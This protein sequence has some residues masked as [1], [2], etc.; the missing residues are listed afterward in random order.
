MDY[1]GGSILDEKY[2]PVEVEAREEDGSKSRV[3]TIIIVIVV[4]LV[5]FLLYMIWSYMEGL[6]YNDVDPDDYLRLGGEHKD[7]AA[8]DLVGKY[9]GK[10]LSPVGHMRLGTTYYLNMKDKQ[11]AFDHFKMAIKGAEEK[12][13]DVEYIA[14]RIQ[15]IIRTG[16]QPIDEMDEELDIEIQRAL[17]EN[18]EER[19]RDLEQIREVFAGAAPANQEMAG[20]VGEI[21]EAKS[22]DE[23]Y[24]EKVILSKT[25]W[26]SDTQNVH[27]S[28]L[29]QELVQQYDIVAAENKK[30][31]NIQL[32]DY[33]GMCQWV[34]ARLGGRPLD[35]QRANKVLEVWDNNYPI[36]AMGGSVSEQ[37]LVMAVWHRIHDPQNAE[38]MNALKEAFVEGILD[39]LE[40]DHVVCMSGRNSKIWQILGSIDY[41]EQMGILRT[42]ETIKN[43]IILKCASIVNKYMTS[44]VV[45][46]NVLEDYKAGT[47]TNEVTELKET[48][49]KEIKELRDEYNGKLPQ[50]Q[51]D[52]L[53]EECVSVI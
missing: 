39:C 29:Y 35:L 31:P 33:K 48:I 16:E 40:N 1:S 38:R 50:E 44:G 3:N 11:R 17:F 27:D 36:Q 46:D 52:I 14:G 45:S 42:K 18:Y 21:A 10:R 30:I 13:Q 26:H 43:T 12:K 32:K 53:I 28:T 20:L 22:G 51:L 25:K 4:V 19:K 5:I 34:R 24:T 49:I 6:G 23:R 2:H 37:D 8:I 7:R 47:V 9:E 41:N 15:D